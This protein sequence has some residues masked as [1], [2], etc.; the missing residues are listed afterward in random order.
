MEYLIISII[1]DT[2]RAVKD[3]KQETEKVYIEIIEDI[4]GQC[5]FETVTQ[6]PDQGPFEDLKFKESKDRIV[7]RKSRYYS[8]DILGIMLSMDIIFTS[9]AKHLWDIPYSMCRGSQLK[10]VTGQGQLVSAV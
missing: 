1:L 7:H 6:Y 8:M 10:S 9:K 2:N 4:F 3:L 5:V